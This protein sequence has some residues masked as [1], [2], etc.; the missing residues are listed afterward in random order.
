MPYFDEKFIYSALASTSTTFLFFG[1][2]TLFDYGVN[3][4]L[5][6]LFA[7][8]ISTTINMYFQFK[9][10]Y[11][12]HKK[13]SNSLFYKYPLGHVFD[14]VT[15]YYVCKYVF[16]R[17]EKFIKYFPDFLKPYFNTIVRFIVMTLHFLFVSYP[18]R[19]YW[20]FA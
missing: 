12:A 2:S 8:I 3:P 6:T 7:V 14:I 18:V 10:L 16:D 4:S 13:L 1:L 19:R 17:R 5:S 9:I 15:V 20:I 11:P